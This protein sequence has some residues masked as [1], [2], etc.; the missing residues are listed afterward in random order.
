MVEI[1]YVLTASFVLR[2]E[3]GGVIE[4]DEE[5]VEHGRY[6]FVTEGMCHF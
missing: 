1:I 3:M 4:R 2:H 5:A 6:F